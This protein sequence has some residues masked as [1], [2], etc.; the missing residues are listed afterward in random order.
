MRSANLSISKNKHVN[1]SIRHVAESPFFLIPTLYW[2]PRHDVNLEIEGISFGF[3]FLRMV[4]QINLRQ[5]AWRKRSASMDLV[6]SN[7]LAA[8]MREE[9]GPSVV[10]PSPDAL[11]VLKSFE[12]NRWLKEL[13]SRGVE[14]S[15]YG[16]RIIRESAKEELVRR[17]IHAQHQGDAKNVSSPFDLKIEGLE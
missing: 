9:L 15:H 4:G 10:G 13:S 14:E 1:I 7:S 12:K 8:I 17:E 5:N 16:L 3:C 11:A 2:L 6:R